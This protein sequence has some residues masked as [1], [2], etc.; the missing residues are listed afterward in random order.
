MEYEQDISKLKKLVLKEKPPGG[1]GGQP[2]GPQPPQ[3]PRPENEEDFPLDDENEEDGDEG[4]GDEGEGDD[5][6]QD[7]QGGQKGPKGKKPKPQEGMGDEELDDEDS[8]EGKSKDAKGESQGDELDRDEQGEEGE[9]KGKKGEEQDKEGKGGG[10]T[11]DEELD[12]ELDRMDKQTPKGGAGEDGDEEIEDFDPDSHDKY[13]ANEKNPNKTEEE[14]ERENE[15]A[16]ERAVHGEREYEK[17][18]GQ[19]GKDAG[20][21]R[22]KLK[23]RGQ[24]KSQVNWRQKLAEFVGTTPKRKLDPTIINKR[25]LM[26]QKTIDPGYRMD[27]PVDPELIVGIDTSGSIS[28][29]AIHTFLGEI[30]NLCFESKK[31]PIVH[32]LFWDTKVYNETI[33][34]SVKMKRDEVLKKLYSVPL[35]PGGTQARSMKKWMDEQVAKTGKNRYKVY[36]GII[37]FS[38]GCVEKDLKKT[39]LPKYKENKLLVFI[40]KDMS[41]MYSMEPFRTLAPGKTYLLNNVK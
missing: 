8:D 27:V 9:G 1:G 36:E 25:N 19:R 40:I 3:P 18:T 38:D 7:S 29:T 15:E 21:A 34:D 23:A 24:T 35:S 39:D 28:V 17:M 2:P 41:G 20:G 26:T 4:E 16:K 10:S 32:V 37:V 30:V 13:K 6:D 5:Q 11:G 22:S 31:T 12:D 14:M 33:I